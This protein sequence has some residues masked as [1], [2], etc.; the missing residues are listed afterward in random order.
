MFELIK[1]VHILGAVGAAGVLFSAPWMSLKLK[2]ADISNKTLLLQGLYFT[3]CFYNI[4]G[5]VT[6]VS[7]V[8]MFWFQHW[9]GLFQVW[10]IVSVMIFVIDSMVEKKWREPANA[11]LKEIMPSDPKWVIETNK[12]HKAVTSQ[13]ICTSLI[14][15]VML[16]HNQLNLNILSLF[17]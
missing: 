8:L 16:L 17:T 11:M 9:Y 4:A 1:M 14:F 15:I 10:F 7:G 5:W 2:N 13:V 6:I 12:L 3:D